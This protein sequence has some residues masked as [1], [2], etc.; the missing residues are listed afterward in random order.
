MAEKR[1]I[2]TAEFKQEAVRLATEQ[3]Y[4]V[5]ETARHLGINMLWRRYGSAPRRYLPNHCPL[6][7]RVW[8]DRNW[9][10]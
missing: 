2:Y 4:G 7:Q 10:A 9:A 3:R 5:A 8:L 1:K 6:G